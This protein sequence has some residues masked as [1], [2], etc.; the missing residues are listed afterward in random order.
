MTTATTAPDPRTVV[1]V[2]LPVTDLNRASAFY[3]AVFGYP[4]IAQTNA[5]QP[6]VYF[7]SGMGGVSGHLFV[8]KPA[9]KPA[10]MVVHLAVPDRL[11]DAMARCLAQGGQVTSPAIAIPPGRF[12]YARDPDGNGIGLFEPAG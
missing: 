1:W 9:S 12:A 4:M 7:D 11:E 10:G 3:R 6:E 8:G 5:G 2:E